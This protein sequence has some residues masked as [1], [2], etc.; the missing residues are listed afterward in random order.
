MSRVMTSWVAWPTRR[1]NANSPAKKNAWLNSSPLARDTR[2]FRRRCWSRTRNTNSPP[3]SRL[4]GCTN[5][6][7]RTSSSS[8]SCKTPLLP[9]M[10][11]ATAISR[12]RHA[13]IVAK[14][15]TS[16]TKV[17]QRKARHA[18][19]AVART[20]GQKLAHVP[21]KVSTI[22]ATALVNAHVGVGAGVGAATAVV[23][24]VAEAVISPET[25]T[26]STM[27]T[28][29]G[30]L[31]ETQKNLKMLNTMPS[32]LRSMQSARKH[33]HLQR[34]I[35]GYQ[36]APHMT[37]WNWRLTLALRGT[38]FHYTSIAACF[39]GTWTQMGSPE[40]TAWASDQ[41]S[42]FQPTMAVKSNNTEQ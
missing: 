1:T 3:L 15:A 34:L 40:L 5:H 17:A 21:R 36:A 18:T 42:S 27:W 29:K 7:C 30:H 10:P 37:H 8:R 25:A 20:T 6:L 33:Q 41:A 19:A 38:Y 31:M 9:S 16:P 4:A 12:T 22:P 14:C 35:Y 23:E 24:G 2:K 32:T 28:K 13:S 11:S 39:P 26:R